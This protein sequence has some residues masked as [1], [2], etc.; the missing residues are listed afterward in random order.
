METVV[1]P[2]RRKVVISLRALIPKTDFA[3]WNLSAES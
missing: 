3:H 2:E 1:F